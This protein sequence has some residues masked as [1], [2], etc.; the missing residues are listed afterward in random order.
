MFTPR[1]FKIKRHSRRVLVFKRSLPVFAFIL[2]SLMLVWPVL[3]AEQ[4][5]QFSVAVKTDKKNTSAKVDMEQVRFYAQDKKK[6]PL[7]VTAPKV[8]ETDPDNQVITLYKPVATYEMG[9]GVKLTS[10]TSQGLIYQKKEEMFFEDEV[11]TTTDTGYK[12]VST[13]VYCDNKNGTIYSKTPVN[14]TGPAGQL[15]A[16]GFKIYDKGDNIDFYGKTDTTMNSEKGKI[17]V[18]SENGLKIAQ[19]PQTI[20]ALQNVVITQ[21]GNTITADK[22]VL[23]YYTKEQNKNENIRQIEAFGHVIA[24]NDIQKITGDHGLYDPKKGTIVMDGHVVLHQG[25]SH[26]D[27]ETATIDMNSGEGTLTPKKGQKAT[28]IRGRLNPQDFKGDE[29]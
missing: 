20:T 25:D 8:L 19:I 6:Q 9:N 10:K 26:M 23:S 21:D 27:G 13:E 3:I 17:R 5:E 2:A 7:T 14:I 15:K 4:K 18:R 24:K 28:R 1:L 16:V 29:K 11:I 22:V 12:A